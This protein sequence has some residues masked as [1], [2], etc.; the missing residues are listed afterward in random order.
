MSENKPVKPYFQL[1][2]EG[3]NDS[4]IE[5]GE[6]KQLVD[7]DEYYDK[8]DQKK[9]TKMVTG[10]ESY[11]STGKLSK[12]VALMY[13]VKDARFFDPIASVANSRRG[14]EGFFESIISGFKKVVE[15][16]IKY[17]KMAVRWITGGVKALLGLR[18]SERRRKE[19]LVVFKHFQEEIQEVMLTLGMP[20]YVADG[21][22]FFEFLDTTKMRTPNITLLKHKLSSDYDSLKGVIEARPIREKT[23]NELTSISNIAIRNSVEL[24]KML[25]HEA[26]KVASKQLHPGSAYNH[27]LVQIKK[28]RSDLQF[29]RLFS[30]IQ[31]FI[32]TVYDVK[33]SNDDIRT[34]FE[35]F[36]RELNGKLEVKNIK[37]DSNSRQTIWRELQAATLNSAITKEQYEDA[38]VGLDIPGIEELVNL[39]D[40]DYVKVIGELVGAPDLIHEYQLYCVETRCFVT[41][42]QLAINECNKLNNQIINI[43]NGYVRTNL[44][45]TGL[46]IKDLEKF[47][48]LN[49]SLPQGE[50]LDLTDEGVYTRQIDFSVLNAQTFREKATDIFEQIVEV[51]LGG[52]KKSFNNLSKQLSVGITV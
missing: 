20:E 26:Q 25:K 47:K 50:R 28:C 32:D 39:K 46:L 42:V 27:L 23:L 3:K 6:P 34:N 41:N 17:I 18:Q 38:L 48:E 36:T 30:S 16:I 2:P 1:D 9:A 45:Y 31:A 12:E 49:K 11:F 4:V 14:C 8:T 5:E 33:I 10:A 40:A 7:L 37:I 44:Y 19:S 15:T 51:D 24:K 29:E 43:E 35:S 21:D 13:G 52:I 22:K